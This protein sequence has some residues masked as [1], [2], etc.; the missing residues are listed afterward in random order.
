MGYEQMEIEA[1]QPQE[2]VKFRV[3]INRLEPEKLKGL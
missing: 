2:R 3:F 1:V